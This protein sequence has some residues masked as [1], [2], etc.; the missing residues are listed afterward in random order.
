MEIV[1]LS[2]GGTIASTSG[3]DGATPAKSGEQLV[4]AVPEVTGYANVTVKQVE[5][6]LSFE[7]DVTT[8]ESIAERVADL[9]D[10]PEVDA[11]VLTHGTD[12]LEETAFYLDAAVAPGTPV[13]LTGAQRRPDEL[14]PDGPANLRTA[15]RA[16]REFADR[17]CGG[18]FV[19]FNEEIHAA[20]YVTKAH[21]SKLEAFGSPGAG[22]VGTVERDTVR[23]IREPTSETPTVPARSLAADVYVVQSGTAVSA[24][25]LDAA[26]QRDADGVVIE[27]TGLGN[28]TASLG[29]TIADATEHVPVVVTS[30]CFD[31]SVAP[32]YG[33]DGGGETLR[34]HGAIF[35]SNL[36]AHKARLA[37]QLALSAYDDHGEI[38]ELFAAF[39]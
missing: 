33:G 28:V 20:R 18:V 10:D 1:V 7:M 8:L 39:G 3:E 22:P 37:L 25:L 36:P 15:F 29:D 26:L 32:V 9:D 5:R 13:F 27:G 24:D 12:T 31:G 38:R 16:A 34:R 19:A 23:V 30:R 21:T 6:T 14:S 11:V 35:A 2:T 17:D 4:S